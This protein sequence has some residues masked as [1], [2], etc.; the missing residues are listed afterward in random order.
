[1]KTPSPS[2]NIGGFFRRF[3]MLIFFLALAGGLAYAL[4]SLTGILTDAQNGS[5][6]TT[7]GNG[8]VTSSQST[9]DAINKLHAS[10]QSATPTLPAGRVNPF[11]E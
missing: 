5:N 4:L 6:A 8:S 1:M 9:I 7:T 10:D 2:L 11:G 3:H